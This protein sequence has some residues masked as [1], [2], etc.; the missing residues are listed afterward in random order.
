MFD[1]HAP[2]IEYTLVE[3]TRGRRLKLSVNRKGNVVVKVPRHTPQLVINRF[4]NQNLDWIIKQQAAVSNAKVLP[5]DQVLLFGKMYQL[6][7]VSEPG[8]RSGCVVDGESLV[9]NTLHEGAMVKDKKVQLMLE[10]FLR[11]TASHYILQRV[12]Q[13]AEKMDI[14][15]GKIQLRQQRSRWGS[16]SST[17]TLNFNWRLVHAPPSVV[18]YVI[19]HE[20]AHR[21][22]MN[23]SSRFWQL[24]AKYDPAHQQHR[25]W[26]KREGRWV[27]PD[28]SEAD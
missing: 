24:V 14:T 21:R 13:W 5:E 16:C 4:I 1:M 3:D 18:D 28:S 9:I 12:P 26:L 25:G 8:R 10:R 7:V 15:Y 27:F 17:G 22:E 19:I 11:T 23:H 6:T 2:F 20:L